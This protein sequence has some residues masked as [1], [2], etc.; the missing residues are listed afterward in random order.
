MT[1]CRGRRCNRYTMHT[2]TSIVPQW[3]RAGRDM[4][5]NLLVLIAC[6]SGW[7]AIHRS[8][9]GFRRQITVDGLL[10]PPIDHS[11]KVLVEQR[12]FAVFVVEVA[13]DRFLFGT[14]FDV[15]TNGVAV[16]G[17]CNDDHV[18]H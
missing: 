14:S 12:A 4:G 2:P 9:L 10:D 3:R 8:R 17:F 6:A 5:A 1:T 15:Q 13:S 11:P 18:A 16:A 7:R